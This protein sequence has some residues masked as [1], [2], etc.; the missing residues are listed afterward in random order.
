MSTAG[1]AGDQ[2]G[3]GAACDGVTVK[4][5]SQHLAYWLDE[6]RPARNTGMAR[7]QQHLHG[8]PFA[9]SCWTRAHGE[10]RVESGNAVEGS[11]RIVW[12]RHTDARLNS[13]MNSVWAP[14]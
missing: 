13:E 10:L 4:A 8:E 1:R 9:G 12:P 5:V 3:W 14:R 2:T 11:R 7:A 6:K